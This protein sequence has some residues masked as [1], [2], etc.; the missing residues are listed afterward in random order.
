MLSEDSKHGQ[1]T[2]YNTHKLH[3]SFTHPH[4]VQYVIE[5][6]RSLAVSQSLLSCPSVAMAVIWAP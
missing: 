3:K 6:I 1:N 5:E 4:N 2:P